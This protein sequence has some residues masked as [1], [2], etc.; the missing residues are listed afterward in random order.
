MVVR[1]RASRITPRREPVDAAAKAAFPADAGEFYR[2]APFKKIKGL[3]ISCQALHLLVEPTGIEP[4]TSTMPL[5]R[6]A[7]FQGLPL[8]SGAF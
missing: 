8:V 2:V 5:S 1:G 4:V 6:M 3:E 7:V